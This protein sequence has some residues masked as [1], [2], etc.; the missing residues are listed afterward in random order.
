MSSFEGK[1]ALLGSP[2]A[3]PFGMQPSDARSLLLYQHGRLRML[4]A[5]CQAAARAN[6]H[7]LRAAIDEL[8]DAFA[9]HNATEQAWL[10]P[11]LQRS[12]DVGE[13][14]IAR[15]I[16]EH[17]A[18]HGVLGTLLETAREANAESIDEIVEE[19][20]AHMAAEERTFL[21]ASVLKDE[22]A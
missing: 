19:L 14:R 18:E 5:R 22:L 8:R 4:L 9:E 2:L 21:S 6:A 1:P 16:E 12:T 13:R 3:R 10:R 15:M 17:G 11:L 7:A 20:E